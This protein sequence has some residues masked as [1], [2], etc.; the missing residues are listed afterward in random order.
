MS[1][2]K[3][4]GKD[5][6]ES[7]KKS[8]ASWTPSKEEILIDAYSDEI[9]DCASE[10]GLNTASWT[11]V[12]SVYNKTAND[13]LESQQLQNKLK[14]L[15]EKYIELKKLSEVSGAGF[16]SARGKV[17]VTNDKWWDERKAGG[18]A[19]TKHLNHF[20]H[21]DFPLFS[22]LDALFS[23][24]T[25]TGEYAT[26]ST[27]LPLEAPKNGSDKR[28]GGYDDDDDNGKDYNDDN[29][30]DDNNNKVFPKVKTGGKAGGKRGRG[31]DEEETPKKRQH[32]TQETGV[33][34]KA[35]NSLTKAVN[36]N[37]DNEQ[38]EL[39]IADL[40]RLKNLP[41]SPEW[42][43]RDMVTVKTALRDDFSLFLNFDDDE[44]KILWI[45]DK[46][47]N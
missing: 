7:S 43:A 25:A 42:S 8:S 22:K 14:D 11:K 36:S 21:K 5:G 37:P 18:K 10:K 6:G 19:N 40:K 3:N 32:I 27:S 20:R 4:K 41:D 9:K 30:D 38:F 44:E 39:A 35:M 17:T 28:A 2:N 29:D 23:T 26:S 34:L 46:L 47:G 15:K 12:L 24:N 31:D 16:D 45:N 13:S 1:K 33:I